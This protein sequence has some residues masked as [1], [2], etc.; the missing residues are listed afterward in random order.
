VNAGRPCFLP[1]GIFLYAD[2][3]LDPAA[4]A[5]NVLPGN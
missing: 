1:D 3:K 2:F 5:F 4:L